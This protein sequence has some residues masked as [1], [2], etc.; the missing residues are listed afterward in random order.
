[1]NCGNVESVFNCLDEPMV[2]QFC[3]TYRIPNSRNTTVLVDVF[4]DM[5]LEKI[6]ARGGK[7]LDFAIKKLTSRDFALIETSNSLL[8]INKPPIGSSSAIVLL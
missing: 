7:K 3:E 8:D 4:E 5:S 1:M 6:L 2:R